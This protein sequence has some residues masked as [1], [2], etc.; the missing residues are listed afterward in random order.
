MGPGNELH[1][2]QDVETLFFSFTFSFSKSLWHG[3]GVLLSANELSFNLNKQIELRIY[4]GKLISDGV[5]VFVM[6]GMQHAQKKTRE[7]PQ[8]NGV[9]V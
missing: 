8:L 3:R 7:M 6:P 1:S 4:Y 9:P 2:C 5:L